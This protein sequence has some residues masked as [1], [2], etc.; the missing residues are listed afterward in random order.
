LT[1]TPRLLAR[2]KTRLAHPL[3]KAVCNQREGARDVSNE[4][5]RLP[6]LFYE[7]EI[8]RALH[9]CGDEFRFEL[10]GHNSIGLALYAAY[11]RLPCAARRTAE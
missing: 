1:G 7:S 5:P 3:L 6:G 2:Q 9:E 11:Q 10:V 8:E 4:W